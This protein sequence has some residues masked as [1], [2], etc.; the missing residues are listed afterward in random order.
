MSNQFR[1]QRTLKNAILLI[2]TACLVFIMMA[3]ISSCMTI[4]SGN[5]ISEDRAVSGF[6]KVLIKGSGNLFI[7]QGDV[8]SL[9]IT[10]EDN[11]IP[12]ITTTV[13]GDTLTISQ[14]QGTSISA[15][16]SRE[17]YLK[18]KDLVSISAS[19]SVN[20]N[21]S[22][23]STKNLNIK[24]TGS[25]DVIISNL[26]ATGVDISASGSGNYTLAGK[27]DNLKIAF[28]GSSDCSAENL[29][30]KE[31]TVKSTGSGNISINVKD[32]LNVFIGGSGT[33]SY[34]GNPTI[35]SKIT[36]SGKLEHTLPNSLNLTFKATETDLIK[37]G[38][39][40]FD[41]NMTL[42][43]SEK[44]PIEGR[45][46]SYRL[47]EIAILAGDI[48]E[49]CVSVTYGYITENDSFVNPGDGTKG[50]GTWSH[51]YREIRIRNIGEGTYEIVSIGTGGGAQ[52]LMPND[53]NQTTLKSSESY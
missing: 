47:N 3:T 15:A 45:I 8:E 51:I 46:A 26:I 32:N 28:S 16:K 31:C 29:E 24:T 4:G 13:S 19:G 35:D 1:N 30:S 25:S 9:T 12:L 5:V 37:L 21:C 53:S 23:L 18:V 34:I 40:V 52:G 10:A 38:E 7:G 6:S 49:F 44:T 50:K 27:T 33:V 48:S 14:K 39:M 42:L 17:I 41:K 22:G 43:E 36:G 11:L 20:I 2:L